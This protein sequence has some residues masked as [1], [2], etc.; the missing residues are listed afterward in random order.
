M[1]FPSLVRLVLAFIMACSVVYA[2]TAQEGEDTE[3]GQETEEIS[4]AAGDVSYIVQPG[5]VLDLIGA[6][7]NVSAACIAETNELRNPNRIFPGDELIIRASCPPYDGF[8]LSNGATSSVE[9]GTQA[10]QSDAGQGGGGEPGPGDQTYVIQPG[11][12]LDGIAQEFNISLISLQQVNDLFDFRDVVPGLTIVIPG[13][14]PPYGVVPPMQE[15]TQQPVNIGQGGGGGQGGGSSASA[16]GSQ[17]IEG[18]IYTV[19]D[20]DTILTVAARFGVTPSQLTV[21]NELFSQI[22]LEPGTQLVIP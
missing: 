22:E 12:T 15:G 20:G 11:D 8:A 17:A 16:D 10:A 13:D 6:G 21:V 4:P 19:Q 3:T 18:N 14:A 5:D 1:N 2:V 7:F 9:A